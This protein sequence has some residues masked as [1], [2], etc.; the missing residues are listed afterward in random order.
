MFFFRPQQTH[1]YTHPH[2]QLKQQKQARRLISDGH[3]I[4]SELQ[5]RLRSEGGSIEQHVSACSK[6]YMKSIESAAAKCEDADF[7]T[8]LNH[9]YTFWHLSHICML[10]KQKSSVVPELVEWLDEN[11]LRSEREETMLGHLLRENPSQFLQGTD[12]QRRE[13]EVWYLFQHF[14]IRGRRDLASRILSKHPSYREMSDLQE[15]QSLVGGSGNNNEISKRAAEMLPS[16]SNQQ[17]SQVLRILSGDVRAIQ[18]V[19]DKNNSW[20]AM[21]SLMLQFN[22]PA[23]TRNSFL[24]SKSRG[25]SYEQKGKRLVEQCFDAKVPSWRTSEQYA[26]LKMYLKIL[27]QDEHSVTTTF[28]RLGLPWMT[29]HMSDLLAHCGQLRPLPSDLPERINL[30]EMLGGNDCGHAQR[31]VYF[32]DYVSSLLSDSNLWE[33]A[34]TYVMVVLF[35]LSL[36]LPSYTHQKTD[37]PRDSKLNVEK[38]AHSRCHHHVRTFENSFV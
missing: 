29:A 14:L 19:Q 22:Q 34:L 36:F 21:M 17:I 35:S 30:V 12:A 13:S 31:A 27:A 37:M 9:A 26:H 33:V 11:F 8:K 20:H 1:T 7:A 24:D 6:L 2:T 15:L 3:R 28:I 10:N 23:L 18:S 5:R 16:A 25:Y 32:E 4:F 38:V